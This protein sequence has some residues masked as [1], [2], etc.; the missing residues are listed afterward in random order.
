MSIFPQVSGEALI[1]QMGEFFSA[2]IQND[3]DRTD[4]NEQQNSIHYPREDFTKYFNRIHKKYDLDTSKIEDFAFR[5]LEKQE[6]AY[7]NFVRRMTM[8]DS[9]FGSLFQNKT[10][11]G[12]VLQELQNSQESPNRN[13]LPR[14]TYVDAVREV[15]IINLYE[16]IHRYGSSS[17]TFLEKTPDELREAIF[18]S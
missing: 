17:L 5:L 1:P 6:R 10:P 14:K 16:K 2:P 15:K 9:F 4:N 12:E 18:G 13:L 11:L 3:G 7:L 8:V